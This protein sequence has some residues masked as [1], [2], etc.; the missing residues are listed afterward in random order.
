MLYVHNMTIYPGQ[1]PEGS[2]KLLTNGTNS[3]VKRL[4]KITDKSGKNVT[5]N[6]YFTL[7]PLS[8]V[9]YTNLKLTMAGTLKN[10]AL[11]SPQLF[12]VKSTI[13]DFKEDPNNI[14]VSYVQ[15]RNADVLMLST[16]HENDDIDS[17]SE[18]SKPK[19]LSSTI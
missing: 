11:F 19:V 5:I 18:A 4:I 8:N 7:V 17:R 2:F 14:L 13:L 6:N 16:L 3:V 10:K 9:L 12:Q 1:Q 15:K